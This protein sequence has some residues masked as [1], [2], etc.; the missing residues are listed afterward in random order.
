MKTQFGVEQISN[1]DICVH[2][3]FNIF[4]FTEGIFS[5]KNKLEKYCQKCELTQMQ[6]DAGEPNVPLPNE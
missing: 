1:Y 4:L 5:L 3:H 6:I 2:F